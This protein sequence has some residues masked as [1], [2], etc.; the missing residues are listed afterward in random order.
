MI[1]YSHAHASAPIRSQRVHWWRL[2]FAV[3]GALAFAAFDL[4]WKAH[5]LAGGP[6]GASLDVP[7][8]LLR[9]LGTMLVGLAALAGALLLPRLCVPGLVSIFAGATSN[10]GS[11]SLWRGVPNPL[12]L[13]VAGGTLHFN[14]ADLGVWGGCLVFLAAALWTIW[15]MPAEAFAPT[16]SHARR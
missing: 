10:L 1:A 11:L 6:T 15:R 7:T 13:G 2:P 3:A 16:A 14:L 9:P 12:S 5:V 8:T 4:S